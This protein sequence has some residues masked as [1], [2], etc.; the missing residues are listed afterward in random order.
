[1]S[2]QPQPRDRA[3]K[4]QGD[5]FD[6]ERLP[7][8]ST[9]AASRL[10]RDPRNS[11]I[12]VWAGA[13]D[14]AE[15]VATVDVVPGGR[16]F[17]RFTALGV[18]PGSVRVIRQR[19]PGG[20]QRL[21]WLCP[22]CITTRA[23]LLFVGLKHDASGLIVGCRTCLGVQFMSRGGSKI[24]KALTRHLAGIEPK[25]PIPRNLCLPTMIT[26][27]RKTLRRFRNLVITEAPDGVPSGIVS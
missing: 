20:G 4:F 6:I 10:L 11:L 5:R 16:D 12:L 8:V 3:G 15:F 19:V 7:A 25:A 14:V 2:A 27:D 17:I 9:H 1:M 23:R 26:S 22:V 21:M 24:R 13:P 18:E